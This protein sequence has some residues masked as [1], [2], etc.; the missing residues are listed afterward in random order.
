LKL[1]LK[2]LKLRGIGKAR[3]LLILTERNS[4]KVF[5]DIYQLEDLGMYGKSIKRL[6]LSNVEAM[7]DI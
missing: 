1:H 7:L 2:L 3:A 5:T 6:V 4:G